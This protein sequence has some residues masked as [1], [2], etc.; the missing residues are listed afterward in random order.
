MSKALGILWD[1]WSPRVESAVA[2]DLI[3]MKSQFGSIQ[4][5]SLSDNP[6]LTR[7]CKA[8]Q[9]ET[10]EATPKVTVWKVYYE[11]DDMYSDVPSYATDVFR[12]CV[13]P[14]RVVKYLRPNTEGYPSLYEPRNNRPAPLGLSPLNK[15][16]P[17][18]T[19]RY[20]LPPWAYL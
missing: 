11:K 15:P 6:S 8:L 14:Q 3:D 1:V 20:L 13:L 7:L 12:K 9:L 18:R 17:P 5:A 19:G 2:R 16:M 4:V 10:V